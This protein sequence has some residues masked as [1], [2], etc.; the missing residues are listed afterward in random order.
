MSIGQY[1]SV[2]VPARRSL[3]ISNHVNHVF[4]VGLDDFKPRQPREEP[5]QPR[6]GGL[7]S[8]ISNH[9]NHEK[10]HVNHVF[11][12]GLGADRKRAIQ[13]VVGRIAWPFFL[14][15]FGFEEGEV[16][17]VAFGCHFGKGN[18]PEGGTV[19]AV[20]HPTG[21]FGAVG[22][23]MS[24]VGISGRGTHLHPVHAVGGVGMFGDG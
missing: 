10:N 12:I 7:N 16:G 1:I 4:G 17:G 22:E 9:V 6:F 11:L 21:G 19:D 18:E 14:L 15:F 5:R 3:D 2:S 20:S 23:D 24:Q 13:T 8:V